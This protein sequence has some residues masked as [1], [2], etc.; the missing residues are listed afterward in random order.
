MHQAGAIRCRGRQTLLEFE[1][2]HSPDHAMKRRQ[3][4]RSATAGAA[5]AG[6]GL[7]ARDSLAAG[8]IRVGILHSQTGTMANSERPLVDMALMTIEDINKAGGVMGRQVSAVVRD[9]G[10]DWDTFAR[11]AR[12]LLANDKVA[13]VFGCWTSASRKAVLPA[14][15]EL[16]GLLYYP[17]QYEGEELERNVFYTGPT[18]N[19]QAMPV[20]S[21]LNSASGG[22]YRRFFLLGSD[23]VYPRTANR[24]VRNFLVRGRGVP[25]GDIAE[26]Y[27]PLGHR[28]YAEIVG[29]IR[30][31]A[32]AGGGKTIVVSTLNGDTNGHFYK[33][34]AAAGIS[35]A[36]VPV[37]AFSVDESELAA[38]DPKPAGH[39]AAWPYFMST[40][41]PENKRLIARF[42]QWTG[43]GQ[44]LVTDPMVA[45]R[46]SLLLWRQAVEQARTTRTEAII[47]A[48][49]GQRLKFASGGAVLM[50]FSNHHL[51]RPI[52]L[53]RIRAD[54]QFDLVWESEGPLRAL[55]FTPYAKDA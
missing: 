51:Q 14:F 55:P 19:Q 38:M 3:F 34:L 40:G 47:D 31:F 5:L 28:D 36:D 48:M 2:V 30:D 43:N 49:A 39:L 25:A 54:G 17:V 52:R 24:I 20:L 23:Y 45:T 7:A 12:D 29:Q 32:R 46:M 1:D 50:D 21:Y 44:A 15:R 10:S 16:N 35:A 22:G 6:F 41:T 53:G 27:T 4:L 13:A 18:P 37:L 9:P 11:M 26:V 33:A 42:R 8:D